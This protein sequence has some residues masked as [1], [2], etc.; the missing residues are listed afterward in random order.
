MHHSIGSSRRHHCDISLFHTENRRLGF[1]SPFAANMHAAN[2]NIVGQII[3]RMPSKRCQPLQVKTRDKRAHFTHRYKY[4]HPIGHDEQY[5]TIRQ[6]INM[7]PVQICIVLALCAIC[8]QL[9]AVHSRPLRHQQPERQRRSKH[10]ALAHSFRAF[11]RRLLADGLL[12][13]IDQQTPPL[14]ADRKQPH[15]KRKGTIN[16]LDML[17]LMPVVIDA[18]QLGRIDKSEQRMLRAV[19]G[20]LWDLMRDEAVARSTGRSSGGAEQQ[21][22]ARDAVLG[23]IL[24]ALRYSETNGR[25]QY[26]STI[27]ERGAS[28]SISKAKRIKASRKRQGLGGDGDNMPQRILKLA[29]VL[30]HAHK[31]AATE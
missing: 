16:E 13:S 10:N 2:E 4:D 29:A 8:A 31:S 28:E 23:D 6:T 12:N 30:I 24:R 18:L 14:Y 19:F 9:S 17:Q 7:Y 1:K 20:G 11:K 3:E 26:L 22:G 25:V 21:R 5:T 27:A 15:R